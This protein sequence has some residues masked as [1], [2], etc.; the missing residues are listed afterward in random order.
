MPTTTSQTE[1]M[2]RAS[3]GDFF[4]LSLTTNVEYFPLLMSVLKDMLTYLYYYSFNFI[5]CFRRRFYH[6][7]E[8]DWLWGVEK[9]AMM[10]MRKASNYFLSC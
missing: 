10:L 1:G 9:E 2:K 6:H 7:N 4:S 8:D 5:F 3:D